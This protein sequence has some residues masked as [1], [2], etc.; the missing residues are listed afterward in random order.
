[1][2]IPKN[3]TLCKCLPAKS[4]SNIQ[5]LEK[6]LLT[7]KQQNISVACTEYQKKRRKIRN[8]LSYLKKYSGIIP[9]A[10]YMAEVYQCEYKSNCDCRYKVYNT[11]LLSFYTALCY[12]F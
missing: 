9:S 4:G 7:S 8:I 3:E 12:S 10:K 5:Y 6:D 1:S 2:V 11:E